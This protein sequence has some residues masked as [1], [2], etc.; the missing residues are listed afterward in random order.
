MRGA[1][2]KFAEVFEDAHDY[3]ALGDEVAPRLRP[4]RVLRRWM[5]LQGAG[6]GRKGQLRADGCCQVLG[7][8]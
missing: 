7:C 5:V 3:D 2:L 8:H 1:R 6:C 4:R